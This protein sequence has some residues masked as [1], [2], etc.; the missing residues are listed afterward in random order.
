MD[1]YSN[2][3]GQKPL[4]SQKNRSFLSKGMGVHK[5]WSWREGEAY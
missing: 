5:K 4:R 3:H 1:I 2:R